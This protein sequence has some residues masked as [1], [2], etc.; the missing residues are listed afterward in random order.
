M[1]HKTYRYVH[2]LQDFVD[3]YNSRPHHGIGGYAPTDINKSN[4]C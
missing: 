3:S 2:L 4:E 1:H